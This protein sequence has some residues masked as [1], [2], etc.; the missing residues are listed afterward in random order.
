ME[1]T[2]FDSTVS[3]AQ[4]VILGSP[5]EEI[6][7]AGFRGGQRRTIQVS[8][9]INAAAPNLF[10]RK[11]KIE[12]FAFAAQRTF[13]G[14]TAMQEALKFYR[15]HP[16]AVPVLAHIKFEQDSQV[17]WLRNCGIE[18]VQLVKLNGVTVGFSYSI[19]GGTDSLT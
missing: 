13:T 19:V 11:T 3:N 17:A 1:I 7:V 10:D 2:A 18:D 8:R 12:S 5:I 6:W 9:P 14:A 16:S 4:P 15:L